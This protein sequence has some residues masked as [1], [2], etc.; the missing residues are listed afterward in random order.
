MRTDVIPDV[1]EVVILPV[2][3]ILGK[4]KHLLRFKVMNRTFWFTSKEG[5]GGELESIKI[6]LDY[7][8]SKDD[9]E[10][11]DGCKAGW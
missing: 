2:T 4:K 3:E 7:S 6:D 9:V 8:P 10:S 11:L 1:E 5:V